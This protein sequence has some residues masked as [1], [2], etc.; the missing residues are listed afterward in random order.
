M[1]LHFLFL[2]PYVASFTTIWT[3]KSKKF[4]SLHYQQRPPGESI[5]Y[6]FQEHKLLSNV[7]RKDFAYE[8]MSLQD[9]KKYVRE[10]G[11][12]DKGHD[13]A[14]LIMIAKGYPEAVRA[15][16]LMKTP[17]SIPP[18]LNIDAQYPN[19]IE[20]HNGEKE[21]MV[22][23]SKQDTSSVFSSLKSFKPKSLNIA[24]MKISSMNLPSIPK[25]NVRLPEL[26][27]P[28]LNLPKIN[29]PKVDFPNFRFGEQKTK[30]LDKNSFSEKE[31][32]IIDV[33]SIRDDEASSSK[34]IM[35]FLRFLPE[36]N[37]FL[38]KDRHAEEPVTNMGG[39]RTETNRSTSKHML[40]SLKNSLCQITGKETYV[41]GDLSRHFLSEIDSSAKF[42]VR[43]INH[44]AKTMSRKVDYII[45]KR[46]DSLASNQNDF[47]IIEVTKQLVNKVSKGEYEIGEI[48]FLC[49]VLIKLGADFSLVAGIL[50][51]KLLL[52]LL[53]YS[54]VIGLGERFVTT[55]CKEL[56][57]RIQE[58]DTKS[59]AKMSLALEA[60]KDSNYTAGDLTKQAL[61]ECLGKDSFETG[62]I[63]NTDGAVDLI[64]DLEECLA[65]EKQLVEKLQ[66]VQSRRIVPN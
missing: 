62:D 50:P 34:N 63:A 22:K 26:Q 48:T 49:K 65:L 25:Q 6:Q 38:K 30:A 27:R 54:L 58:N 2:L 43:G 36:F 29:A 53:G 31:E 66:K 15:K 37:T 28:E 44:D 64:K 1:K 21:E 35:H 8:E 39:I 55:L 17:D 42:A 46:V 19:D 13:R 33:S 7:R 57:K 3:N 20:D 11:F 32:T 10:I 18:R 23:D 9:M 56:D 41:F 12:D 47:S 60:P 61:R 5:N 51:V 24:D 59:P 52:D 14:A 45:K 16:P 40:D 4:G